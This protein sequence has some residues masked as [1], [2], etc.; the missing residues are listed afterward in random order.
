MI[1]Q[2]QPKT[3]TPEE[4]LALEEVADQRHEYIDGAIIPMAGGTT[5]HNKIALNF[6][7][8][9]PLT[10]DEQDYEVYMSDVRLWIP[11]V[12]RYT[13]PDV[14]IVAAPTEYYDSSQTT[15]TNPIVIMEILCR[16]LQNDHRFPRFKLFRSIPT[17]QE[18][19]L[20]HEYSPWVE[21]HIRNGQ[22]EWLLRDYEGQGAELKLATVDFVIAL[23]DLYDHIPFPPEPTISES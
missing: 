7:R 23:S 2:T 14:M 19:I 1:A 11:D 13:Y 6:C 8:R 3:Y 21:Q 12:R 18:Y 15:I 20:I 22:G 4:Y 5:N 9:F 10:I 16:S 17:L